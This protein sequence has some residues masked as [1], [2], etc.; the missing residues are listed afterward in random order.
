MC[1][2]IGLYSDGDSDFLTIFKK[3][4]FKLV[5]KNKIFTYQSKIFYCK[6]L[7]ILITVQAVTLI[8]CNFEEKNEKVYQTEIFL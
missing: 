4:H 7:G 6:G 3:R 1:Q 5:Q 2:Y 8:F